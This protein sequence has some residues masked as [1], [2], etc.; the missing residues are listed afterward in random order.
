MGIAETV[1][2]HIEASHRLYVKVKFKVYRLV[3]LEIKSGSVIW[4][5]IVM[6]RFTIEAHKTN[7]VV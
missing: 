4:N 7:V 5:D 1:Y 2:R 3:V 6:Y